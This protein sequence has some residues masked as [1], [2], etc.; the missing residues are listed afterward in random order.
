MVSVLATPVP[1]GATI[2]PTKLCYLDY[3][4]VMRLIKAQRKLIRRNLGS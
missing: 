2:T 3:A 4:V 1:F